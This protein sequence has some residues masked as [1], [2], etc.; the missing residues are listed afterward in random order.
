MAGAPTYS[1]IVPQE[2]QM[3]EIW[4]V[5]SSCIKRFARCNLP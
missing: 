3:Q 4:G 1:D 2:G 5:I